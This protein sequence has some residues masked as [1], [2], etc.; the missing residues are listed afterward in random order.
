MLIDNIC[1]GLMKFDNYTIL[2]VYNILL[3]HDTQLSSLNQQIFDFRKTNHNFK[4][5]WKFS[6]SSVDEFKLRLSFEIWVKVFN[7]NS[8]DADS[9]YNKFLD[10]Y[11][12]LFHFCFPKGKIYEKSPTK[13][14]ITTKISCQKKKTCMS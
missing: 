7:V 13:H 8:N 2:P 11:L 6:K 5:I 12:Q 1:I 14:W 4:I 10:T 9:I 3:D